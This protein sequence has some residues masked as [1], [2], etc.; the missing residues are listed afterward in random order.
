MSCISLI[1]Y[2]NLQVVLHSM[3][4]IFNLILLFAISLPGYS[5]TLVTTSVLPRNA[6]VEIFNGINC[7]YCPDGDSRAEQLLS[8]YPGRVVLIFI[9]TGALADTIFPGQP[10][11]RT[12]FGPAID[13]MCATIAYPAGNVNRVVWP[14]TYSQPPYFPQ[15]PPGNLVL[16]RQGWWDSAYPS[17]G[18]GANIILQGGN[19]PVNIGA[20]C[21][22]DSISRLLTVNIEL[23]YTAS[24]NQDNKLN[25]ALT[26]NNVIGIQSDLP[27][28][29]SN[30]VHNHMLRHLL[31]GQWGD[32]VTTTQQGTLVART[33]SYTVP[34]GFNIDNCEI[35][36]FVTRSDNKHTHTGITLAAKDGTTVGINEV[37]SAME[38]GIFPNP[39]DDEIQITGLNESVL[40][41]L[42][43]ITGKKVMELNS[44]P[45]TGTFDISS[46]NPGIYFISIYSGDDKQTFPL[47]VK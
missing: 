3:K 12:P 33:Y 9:H 22:F 30:Y 38:I 46:L 45:L 20:A 10:D 32:T 37:V 27:G 40:V 23:Y 26:E 24:E 21:S 18:A 8:S 36:A 13:S 28:Y 35:S 39:A 41:S 15:N 47:M 11:Y 4:V 29:D 5:Q 19:T 17:T 31:T 43:D 14:G 34:Q 7:A 42:S 1:N 2:I 44:S 16:R 6:V 25:V